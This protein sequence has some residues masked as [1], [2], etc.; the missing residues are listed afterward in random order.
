[1]PR[2]LALEWNNA[3]ARMVVASTHRDRFVVEQ[4][5]SLPFSSTEPGAE[6]AE[7][8]VGQQIAAALEA[9]GIRRVDTLVA[10]GRSNIELRQLS[11]PPAPAEE[12]PDMVRIQALRDFNALEDNW[13][14]DFIPAEYRPEQPVKVLAAAIDPGLME[15]LLATCQTAGLKPLRL[16]LRPCAAASLLNRSQPERSAQFRLL[17]DLL[18]DEADLT[19]LLE[20]RVTFLRTARLPGDPLAEGEA[21]QALLGEIRRTMAAAQNALGSRPVESI[22]LCGTGPT[23]VALAQSLNDNLPVPTEL[24]DPFAGRQ[25]GPHVRDAF[26]ARPGRFAPLLGMLLDEME[27]TP[28]AIDFLHPRRRPPPPNRRNQY[29]AGG[30][31]AALLLA[32]FFYYQWWTKANLDAQ[33]EALTARSRELD[34]LVAQAE[35]INQDVAEI[36]K[37]TGADIIWLDELRELCADFPPAV[38][39]MLT[40]LVMSVSGSHGGEMKFEGLA[41]TAA[42]IDALE[43]GL[44]DKAHEVEGKG[45]N[46]VS[47][48]NP[49]YAWHFVSSLFVHPEKL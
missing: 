29:I 47:P 8:T 46:L 2:L 49:N 36:G 1:M 24:F 13:P 48:P 9:H 23:Q 4:A 35:K 28:H 6:P 14:L 44:R 26:P 27:H 25:I 22:V 17:V 33:I 21:G 45:S 12:L 41:R 38:D 43:R 20:G 40:Q 3:E 5:F 30:V 32:A 18:G 37:W 7:Q 34:P 15:Q 16:I 39:A 11:L 31:A 42:S 19:V 10:V